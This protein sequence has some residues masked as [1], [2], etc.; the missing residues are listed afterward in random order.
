M[1]LKDVLPVL[2]DQSVKRNKSELTIGNDDYL[3]FLAEF[4]DRRE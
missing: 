3:R 1:T 2:V 4:G